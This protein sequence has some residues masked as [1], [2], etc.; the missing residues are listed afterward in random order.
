MSGLWINEHYLL[1][2]FK[3]AYSKTG[4]AFICKIFNIFLYNRMSKTEIMVLIVQTSVNYKCNCV[5]FTR[6]TFS[7]V[8]DDNS[9]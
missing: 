1:L 5:Q 9:P 6:L 7:Y 2:F 3:N 8:A 4:K